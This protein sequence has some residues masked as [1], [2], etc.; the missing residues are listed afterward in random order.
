MLTTRSKSPART[1]ARFG[2]YTK[3]NIS[4]REPIEDTGIL[5]YFIKKTFYIF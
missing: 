4:W 2:C 5:L 3:P 1:T